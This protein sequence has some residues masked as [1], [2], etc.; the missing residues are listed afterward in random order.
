MLKCHAITAFTFISK[1]S[2]QNLFSCALNADDITF[3]WTIDEWTTLIRY[4]VQI[5]RFDFRIF[6][7]ELFNKL[8][9]FSKEKLKQ[10]QKQ[11]IKVITKKLQVKCVLVIVS[12]KRISYTRKSTWRIKV[13][14][15]FIKFFV[16]LKFNDMKICASIPAIRGCQISN[17]FSNKKKLNH[18]N[19]TTGIVMKIWGYVG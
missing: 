11:K 19:L 4:Y 16:N 7:K 17:I 9:K 14:V 3:L 15:A 1:I 2:W 13:I 5:Y 12:K 18:W 8:I 6:L 10:W